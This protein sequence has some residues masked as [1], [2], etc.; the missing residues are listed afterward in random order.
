M[1][2][3]PKRQWACVAWE[4]VMPGTQQ[5]PARVGPK[6]GCLP[7]VMLVAVLY[8]VAVCLTHEKHRTLFPRAPG[9]FLTTVE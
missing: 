5:T 3:R 7:V 2:P 4:A 9:E 1:K 8:A 6:A